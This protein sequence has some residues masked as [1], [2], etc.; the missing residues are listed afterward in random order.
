MNNTQIALKYFEVSNQSDF[1][2][3]EK[4]F[5]ENITYSSQNT[6]L[7]LWVQDI[8]EMQKNFHGSFES[9]DWKILNSQEEKPGI[10]RVDFEFAWVKAWE[11]VK[12][13]GVEYVIVVDG[14]IQHIEIKNK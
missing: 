4:L 8:L 7:Y 3:I 6:G 13:I 12:F 9:L 10:M 2:E 14:K 1:E 11:E 5:H